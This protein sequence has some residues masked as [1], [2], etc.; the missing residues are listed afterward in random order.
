MCLAGVSEGKVALLIAVAKDLTSR[1][2]AG[3]LVAELAPIIG[4]KGGGKP[5]LAQAGGVKPEA[6]DELFGKLEGLLS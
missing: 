1:V 3:K 2:Q 6:I 4:G 5:D